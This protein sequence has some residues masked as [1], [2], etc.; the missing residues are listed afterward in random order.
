MP[1]KIGIFGSCVSRDPCALATASDFAV[2]PYVARQSSV[3]L[4]DE[5]LAFN[6]DWYA[7]LKDFERRCVAIDLSKTMLDHLERTSIDALILDL[8]DER[9]D[10]LKVN[11][12][13]LSNA[14]VG[15]K[16]F[17]DHYA[18]AIE[19]LP[20][21]G[22]EVTDSWKKGMFR[23]LCRLAERFAKR[24]LILHEA[25]WA[26]HF[27]TKEGSLRQYS[28]IY[29]RLGV[30]HNAILSEYYSHVRKTCNDIG[31]NLSIIRV[32]EQFILGDENHR[33]SKEPFHYCEEYNVEFSE[34]LIDLFRGPAVGERLVAPRAAEPQRRGTLLMARAK[35]EAPHLLEW[36]CYHKLIGF[37]DILIYSNDS[38]DYTQD[39]LDE[40]EKLGLLRHVRFP[41]DDNATADGAML[42][43]LIEH[44]KRGACEWGALLDIDEFLFLHKHASVA[45]FLADFRE[46]DA[47][48]INWMTFGSAGLVTNDGRLT[49][50]R[51]TKCGAPNWRD[52]KFVKSIARLD[53]IMGGGPH[54][55]YLSSS[56]ERYR[57]ASGRKFTN[58]KDAAAIDHS[59][60]SIFHY[61]VRSKAEFRAK[62]RRGDAFLTQAMQ[63]ERNRYDDA[64][65]RSRDVNDEECNHMSVYVQTIKEKIDEIL[66][67][68]RISALVD[69]INAHQTAAAAADD[70]ESNLR[71]V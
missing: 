2:G 57:H 28:P 32:S 25:Y 7:E 15:S 14:H 56:M 20:R 39:L 17:C 24:P 66:R 50:E 54:F 12:T 19:I 51:F 65:F 47:V 27:R 46:A 37:D 16:G 60:A 22:Q 52:N 63:A 59:V 61:G 58:Y 26:T 10:I 41:L 67:H 43:A 42:K 5:P 3:G 31:L 4:F 21:L 55:F 44:G 70:I 30:S 23:F 34:K 49:I 53:V 38:D 6:P 48:A 11:G 1:Y 62:H 36:V 35:N 71:T 33:W 9:F 45:E 8:I 64:H 69:K 68:P 40:L 13:R 29:T 18:G